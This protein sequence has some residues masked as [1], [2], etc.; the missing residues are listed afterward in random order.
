V[1]LFATRLVDDDVARNATNSADVCRTASCRAPPC[2]GVERRVQGQGAVPKVLKAVAAR[3][4]P[5]RVAHRILAVERLD[6]VFSSHTEH[7]RMRRRVQIQPNDV[8]G[9]LLKGLGRWSPW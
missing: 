6:A 8:G 3:R 1:N 9:L 5:A 4:V 7:R 2:L